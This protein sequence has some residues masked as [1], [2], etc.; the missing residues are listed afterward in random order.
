[1]AYFQTVLALHHPSD[2]YGEFHTAAGVT[3]MA[4]MEVN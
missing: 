2:L 3:H 4:E 1:M